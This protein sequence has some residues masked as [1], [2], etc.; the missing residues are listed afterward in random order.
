MQQRI[1]IW[2]ILILEVSFGLCASSV[3]AYRVLGIAFDFSFLSYRVANIVLS[4]GLII[5]LV[6]GLLKQSKQILWWVLW[7]S[8]FHLIEGIIIHFWFKVAIHGAILVI[9]GIY[10]LQHRTL[11]FTQK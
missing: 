9:V 11:V 6:N 10:Y 2:S 4:I 7:F 5:Y 3:I 1:Y 8:A